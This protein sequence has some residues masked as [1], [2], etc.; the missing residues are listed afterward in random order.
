MLHGWTD[1][2]VSPKQSSQPYK[3]IKIS[4]LPRQ[5][6]GTWTL[7]QTFTELVLISFSSILLFH[8]KHAVV[9]FTQNM[10]KIVCVLFLSSF[11]SWEAFPNLPRSVAGAPNLCAC[12]FQKIF[13]TSCTRLWCLKLWIL[14][15]TSGIVLG[16]SI[17]WL[18]GLRSLILSL[19]H[20]TF[21]ISSADSRVAMNT[22]RVNIQK[23][24]MTIAW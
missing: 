7:S 16:S 23:V 9:K 8:E 5:S 3:Q 2:S 17:Y 18:F 20:L 15:Q 24:L 14:S 4:I 1:W 13:Q 11:T 12:G 22:K 19:L 6:P 10:W 21:P